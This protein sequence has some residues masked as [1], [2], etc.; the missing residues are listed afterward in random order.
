[1]AN[2]LARVLS[3]S[4]WAAAGASLSIM[5]RQVENTLLRMS[6]S[7]RSSWAAGLRRAARQR[8]R[9]GKTK[10]P[11]QERR[12]ARAW[13]RGAGSAGGAP[14]RAGSMASTSSPTLAS[15]ATCWLNSRSFFTS[16][17]GLI[18]C[19]KVR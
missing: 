13:T 9:A 8:S 19:A 7:R 18:P 14:A 2:M 10:A 1:V 5:D 17:S 6:V 11:S 3:A 16:G 12:A 4:I 15:S